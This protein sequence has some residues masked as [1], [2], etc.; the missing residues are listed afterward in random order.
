MPKWRR[1]DSERRQLNTQLGAAM[2]EAH[3]KRRQRPSSLT[4]ARAQVDRILAWFRHLKE[5]LPQGRCATALR[6]FVEHPLFVLMTTLL[7]SAYLCVLAVTVTPEREHGQELRMGVSISGLLVWAVELQLKLVG[8]GRTFTCNGWRML[9]L[10]SYLSLVADV[11]GARG[12]AFVYLRAIELPKRYDV[13]LNFFQDRIVHFRRHFSQGVDREVIGPEKDRSSSTV[14]MFA[15]VSKSSKQMVQ[16]VLLTASSM[17][18]VL[19]MI[20]IFVMLM[21]LLGKNF[22]GTPKSL[23]SLRNRCV[24]QVC[25]RPGMETPEQGQ[26]WES[27]SSRWITTDDGRIVDSV[28]WAVDCDELAQPSLAIVQPESHCSNSSD[29]TSGLYHCHADGGEVC[30]HLDGVSPLRGFLSFDNAGV[31]TAIV[32]LVML[33]QDFTPIQHAIIDVFGHVAVAWF[34]FVIMIGTYVL[35]NYL[36]ALLCN[37]YQVT[38]GTRAICNRDDSSRKGSNVLLLEGLNQSV[39]IGEPCSHSSKHHN[40]DSAVAVEWVGVDVEDSDVTETTGQVPKG[41]SFFCG[42]FA[43]EK[44]THES[45]RK[46]VWLLLSQ[47]WSFVSNNSLMRRM[48]PDVSKVKKSKFLQL[49]VTQIKRLSLVLVT[50]PNSVESAEQ[51][52][53]ETTACHPTRMD[54][55]GHLPWLHLVLDM[56]VLVHTGVLSA[57]T[58]ATEA[59]ADR[60]LKALDGA[61]VLFFASVELVR[62]IAF[63][64]PMN[65]LRRSAISHFDCAISALTLLVWMT[66]QNHW[67]Q[68]SGFRLLRLMM[69]ILTVPQFTQARGVVS[70][71]LG[72]PAELTSALLTFTNFLFV[73]SWIALQLLGSTA[74]EGGHQYFN[75]FLHSVITMFGVS[76]GEHAQLLMSDGYKHV[77]GIAVFFI[78]ACNILLSKIVSNI[79]IAVFLSNF[80]SS[81]H[82]RVAYQIQFA[83]LRSLWGW[84]EV[85]AKHQWMT[86]NTPHKE[87]LGQHGLSSILH[88]D[89]AGIFSRVYADQKNHTEQERKEIAILVRIREAGKQAVEFLRGISMQM[90]SAK[91]LSVFVVRGSHLNLLDGPNVRPNLYVRVR[92]RRKGTCLDDADTRLHSR[93]ERDFSRA[94]IVSGDSASPQRGRP[95]SEMSSRSSDGGMKWQ[96]TAVQPMWNPEWNEELCLGPLDMH[97]FQENIAEARLEGTDISFE[98]W[99]KAAI[100]TLRRAHPKSSDGDSSRPDVLLGVS[101][102]RMP[103]RSCHDPHFVVLPVREFQP[104][105]SSAEN[106]EHDCD[107]QE[108]CKRSPSTMDDCSSGA[109]LTVK[110]ML[111]QINPN[112]VQVKPGKCWYFLQSFVRSRLLDYLY[113]E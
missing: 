105:L 71:A 112:V 36:T 8:Y 78:L 1:S 94:G 99:C 109:T 88:P 56:L 21:A 42:F 103:S 45:K 23:S 62:M 27:R 72:S 30:L 111:A 54:A 55:E 38:H 93:E 80:R 98:L 33:Q 107:D 26:T 110:L 20:T 68:F 100:T 4:T 53:R 73:C 37:S 106:T 101:Q 28:A 85:Q 6:E 13:V 59:S 29:A 51:M 40:H 14:G 76:I 12:V 49:K 83:K 32:L 84:S 70:V 46:T 25:G 96:E 75:S 69:S 10:L 43:T 57:K 24:T 77:G 16:T 35:L 15:K 79:F 44:D 31:A 22:F 90:T 81:D 50:F 52:M 2:V 3:G 108:K 66:R 95:G 11:C 82:D 5:G 41:H 61:M 102:Y 17:L 39:E 74:F 67:L 7:L 65:Y 89:T 9:E 104:R 60:F 19:C 113:V 34:F 97:D 48:V 18:P 92:L 87:L 91:Y 64:G 58:N 47:W 86:R 63:S